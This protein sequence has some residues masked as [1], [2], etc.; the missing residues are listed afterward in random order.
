MC[1]MWTNFAKYGNPTPSSDTTLPC[2]W[3]TVQKIEE[4]S[5]DFTLDCLRIDK[6]LKM[7]QNPDN[8]RMQFWRGI[9][10]K[11]NESFLKPKL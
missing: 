3:T 6:D 5:K 11:W 7:V 1:R 10:E 8:A 9:F 4:N 2:Q